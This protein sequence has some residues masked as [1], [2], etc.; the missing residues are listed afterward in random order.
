[1]WNSAVANTD[2]ARIAFWSQVSAS[3]VQTK[4]RSGKPS[5][6][7]ARGKQDKRAGH[8]GPLCLRVRTPT[9]RLR[10]R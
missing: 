10:H 1:M 4:S 5:I 6:A 3:Q 2:G 9:S 7:F 8:Y